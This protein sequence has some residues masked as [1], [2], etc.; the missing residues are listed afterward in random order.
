MV[1]PESKIETRF[2]REQWLFKDGNGEIVVLLSQM[3]KGNINKDNID[4]VNMKSFPI[5]EVISNEKNGGQRSRGEAVRTDNGGAILP[6]DTDGQ[7]TSRLLEEVQKEDVQG[8]GGEG[9][10]L[11]LLISEGERLSDLVTELTPQIGLAGAEE[12]AR[13]E[14]YDEMMS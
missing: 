13:S 4:G 3:H 8:N 1:T 10:L 9:T 14:I 12:M 5:K 6:A 2:L 11:P 7:G